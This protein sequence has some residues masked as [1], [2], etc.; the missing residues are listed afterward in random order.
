MQNDNSVALEDIL[1]IDLIRFL[2]SKW[3]LILGTTSLFFFIALVY[4]FLIAVPMYKSTISVY[5]SNKENGSSSQ[6][7]TFAAQLGFGSFNKSKDDFNI[8]DVANSTSLAKKILQKKWHI[9]RLDTIMY[10]IDFWELDGDTEYIRL[11]LGV[12]KLKEQI[13]TGMNDETGLINI[14]FESRDPELSKS[15][16]NYIGFEIQNYIQEKQKKLNTINRT[17]IEKRLSIAKRELEE[18]E[19][20][21]EKYL[22]KNPTTSES[23][24]L[25]I[26][27]GRLQ[28][29]VN[30]KLE[31]YKS[32]TQQL[33]L[34]L[35]EEV[36]KVQIINILDKGDLP[37][38]KS[39]PR[40]LFILVLTISLSFILIIL[41]L[42][43]SYIN[44][45]YF[46][47]NTKS[48]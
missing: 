1:L 43:I 46:Y 42:S 35:I 18:A 11:M 27:Y 40:R 37:I 39:S 4:V 48:V 14:S 44:N 20:D 10:L 33:E 5:P 19:D 3:K 36:R 17:F 47:K 29:K 2:I 21:L 45:L 30:I 32:L 41:L 24:S 23:P 25:S 31:V 22:I 8:I 34:A 7:L 12:E 15:I 13:N 9:S 6:I 26:K 28:R 16:I 38:K